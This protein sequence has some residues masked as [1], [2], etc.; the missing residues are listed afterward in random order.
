MNIKVWI[1]GKLGI[2]Q[3]GKCRCEA[4]HEVQVG[5]IKRYIC[6]D[7]VSK[8][9]FINKLKSIALKNTSKVKR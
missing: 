7:H 9:T 6:K 8:L 5:K 2:C 4:T 1:K 3:W